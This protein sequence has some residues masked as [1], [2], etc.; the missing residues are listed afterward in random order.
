VFFFSGERKFVGVFLANCMFST[1][2]ANR[3]V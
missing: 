2:E 1:G 3:P